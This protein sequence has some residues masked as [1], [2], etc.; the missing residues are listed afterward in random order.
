[1]NTRQL[2]FQKSESLQT[3][4]LSRYVDGWIL[5]CEI[6]HCSP[7][8]VEKR[9]LLLSK[10]LWFLRQQDIVTVDRLACRQ[11]L[12]YLSQ[13]HEEDGGRWGTVR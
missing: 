5:E 11:F 12:R 7:R 4:G 9:H 13:G 2:P 6:R 8:T 1:M 10:F 3:A